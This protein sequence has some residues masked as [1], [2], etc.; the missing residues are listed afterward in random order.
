MCP[1]ASAS[2][3]FFCEDIY[4]GDISLKYRNI[5][6]YQGGPKKKKISI[7]M[8]VSAEKVK[9]HVQFD[10][11]NVFKLEIDVYKNYRSIIKYFLLLF[12]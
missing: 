8:T 12:F 5:Y 10:T 3:A 1:D 4:F 7:I 2:T 9:T 6:T 11:K